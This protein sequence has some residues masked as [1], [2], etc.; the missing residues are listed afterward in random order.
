[1]AQLF[2][3]LRF[4]VFHQVGLRVSRDLAATRSNT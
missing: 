2:Y 3:D 1:M 4:Q